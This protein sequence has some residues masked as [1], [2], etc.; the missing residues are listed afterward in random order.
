MSGFLI[1]LFVCGV[2]WLMNHDKLGR[3]RSDL[4]QLRDEVDRLKQRLYEQEVASHKQDLASE[5][6][7]NDIDF[8]ENSCQ[9]DADFAESI[10]E[11]ISFTPSEGVT[12][13]ATPK[14]SLNENETVRLYNDS[15]ESAFNH[16]KFS[17]KLNSSTLLWLGAFILALGGVFLA[18]FAIEGGLI[19]PAMRV[20]T[21][22][23]FGLILIACAEYLIRNP[24]RYN[25]QTIEVSAAL[26]AAG[27]VTC[28]SMSLVA[29]H[30]YEMLSLPWSFIILALISLSATLL[31]LRFG[32]IVAG[33]GIIG[34]YAVPVFFLGQLSGLMQLM[35]YVGLVSLSAVFVAHRVRVGWLWWLSFTGHYIWLYL[36]VLFVESNEVWVLVT[37]CLLSLYIFVLSDVLGWKFTQSHTV[38]LRIVA[39]AVPRKEQLGLIAAVLPVWFYYLLNGYSQGL[40]GCT[41]VFVSLLLVAPTRHSTLDTWPLLAL[42]LTVFTQLIQINSGLYSARGVTETSL[43]TVA[44]SCVFFSYS[45]A[46]QY[47]T[48]KRIVYSALSLFAPILLFAVAYVLTIH[49]A[50][51]AIHT[52]WSV[53]LFLLATVGLVVTK[54]SCWALVRTAGWL[55]A[56]LYLL[57]IA[58]ILFDSSVLTSMYALQ[59]LFVRYAGKQLKYCTPSWLIKGIL[60]LV[61][62]R[63]TLAPWLPPYMNEALFGIHWTVIVYPAVFALLHYAQ[64][65]EHR[66]AN[67]PWFVA[68][69]IHIAAL[70]VTT[71]TSYQL[72]GH[73]PFVGQLSFEECLLLALNWMILGSVYLYRSKLDTRLTQL[74]QLFAITL[75]FGSTGLYLL[76]VTVFNPFVTN[77]FVGEL[78]LANW[79]TLLWLT[80]AVIV[81]G[82]LKFTLIDE[83]FVK[84]AKS[85]L[86][87]FVFV[88]INSVIRHSFYQGYVGFQLGMGQLELYTYS[89]VWLLLSVAAIFWSQRN[90]AEMINKA[91]FTILA[92]VVAKAFI[93][94]MAELE[95]LYRALSF[96]G[97][98]LCLIGIGWLFQRLRDSVRVD[99]ASSE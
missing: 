42:L 54:R 62:I 35:I 92:V 96:I 89:L 69:K 15:D 25:I 70:F 66:N 73:Y 2:I 68:A 98:G 4:N 39:L 41:F 88:F 33:V 82:I 61:I 90:Q 12:A 59:L 17:L 71:E 78:P 77:Q 60:S 72:L 79:L 18:K 16:P 57:L 6:T 97:L 11:K 30:Y 3:M 93:I 43:Y 27:I 87:A 81:G 52:V 10:A 24:E 9:E 75:F 55:A 13:G 5:V 58:T 40:I 7:K 94:D 8:V 50:T 46:M 34:A 37:F 85:I 67:L 76:L 22:A 14:R 20:A 95:G 63:L 36:S 45:L 99:S 53:S 26:V 29:S 38:A 28:Y 83:K 49:K 51:Q 31:A 64:Q 65:G 48:P 32:P 91:G 74:Y 19:S 84:L 56:N 47:F 21:G 23:V 1:L 44:S 86:V 80:P